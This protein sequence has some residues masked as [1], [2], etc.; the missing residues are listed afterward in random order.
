MRDLF[1]KSTIDINYRAIKSIEGQPWKYIFDPSKLIE[2]T[3]A[4]AAPEPLEVF[5]VS[6]IVSVKSDFLLYDQSKNPIINLNHEEFLKDIS[7]FLFIKGQPVSFPYELKNN[8]S[9]SENSNAYSITTFFVLSKLKR[10]S[11]PEDFYKPRYEFQIYYKDTLIDF[12]L[13][14][15]VKKDLEF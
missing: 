8:L 13:L 11:L 12:R 9:N 10:R 5:E 4:N 6:K 7:I 15:I 3:A 14:K 1:Q 2:K